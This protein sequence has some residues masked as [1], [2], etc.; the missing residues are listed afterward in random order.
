MVCS[1]RHHS[2]VSFKQLSASFLA[3]LPAET[4]SKGCADCDRTTILCILDT[5]PCSSAQVHPDQ[6]RA[7]P[8]ASC[9]CCQHRP[10]APQK[11]GP[12]LVICN[13]SSSKGCAKSKGCQ[14]RGCHQGRRPSSVVFNPPQPPQ[15]PVPCWHRSIIA[16]AVGRRNPH[17]P[18]FCLCC[19]PSCF[20]LPAALVQ[21]THMLQLEG[22][23]RTPGA[24]R[25]LLWMPFCQAPGWTARGASAR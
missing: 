24:G 22:H 11:V 20:C 14:R 16:D 8:Q 7:L 3:H 1:G 15:Q 2:C 23:R 12:E 19:L 25:G 21:F 13:P 17:V 9:A 5:H 4:G 6:V 10:A 18:T